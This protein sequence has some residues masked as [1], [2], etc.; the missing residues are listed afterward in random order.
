MHMQ[1]SK[2]GTLLLNAW[3]CSGVGV[4]VC[5]CSLKVLAQCNCSVYPDKI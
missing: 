1:I 5:V 4:C 2:S 3:K